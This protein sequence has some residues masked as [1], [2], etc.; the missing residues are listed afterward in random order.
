MKKIIA[1]HLAK[2]Q[3]DLA[4]P[5]RLERLRERIAA[6]AYPPAPPDGPVGDRGLRVV[7]QERIPVSAPDW[8][9]EQELRRSGLWTMMEACYPTRQAQCQ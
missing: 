8:Y 4:E 7:R 6:N 1:R 9:F 2:L 3:R 5:S